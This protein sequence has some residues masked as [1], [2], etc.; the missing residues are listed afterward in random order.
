[1]ILYCAGCHI[2]VGDIKKGSLLKNGMICLCQ[3]CEAKRKAS[4]L[5]KKTKPNSNPFEP[6]SNPFEGMFDL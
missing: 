1:M 5:A 2:K 3:K 6:N 4:D